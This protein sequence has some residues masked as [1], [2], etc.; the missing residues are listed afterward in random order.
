M[1]PCAVRN[2]LP[3]CDIR[4]CTVI[5]P[6]LQR[7]QQEWLAVVCHVVQR[8]TQH[9]VG[10]LGAGTGGGVPDGG[11]RWGCWRRVCGSEDAW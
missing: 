5:L 11:S 1:Q 6:Y 8:G 2:L 7:V 10:A 4:D 3:P 9:V